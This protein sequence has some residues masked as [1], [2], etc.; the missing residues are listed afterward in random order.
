MFRSRTLRL[1]PLAAAC[2]LLT[3][4]RPA[5]AA[6]AAPV[7][8]HL[9]SAEITPGGYLDMTGVWRSANTGNSLATAFGAIPFDNTAA[10]H[11][12]ELRMTAQQ[13]RLNLRIADDVNGTRLAAYAEIDWSGNSAAN[14]WVDSNSQTLRMRQFW[15]SVSRGP[16]EFLAGQAW[17]WITPNRRGLS[18]NPAELMTTRNLDGF[19]NVGLAWTRGA[20]FRAAWHASGGFA[21]GVSLENPQQYVGASEVTFPSAFNAQLGVQAD[22]ANNAGT[23]NEMPD[24]V[25][26]AVWDGTT[27]GGPLH[28]EAVGIT[29]RFHIAELATGA[30]TFSHQSA[31]GTGAGAAVIA[32]LGTRLRVVASGLEGDGLGRY[33][34]GL[35]PDFV[36]Q[37]NA[38]GTDVALSTVHGRS[39]IAG[40]ESDLTPTDMIAGYYGEMD[41]DRDAFLDTT[42]PVTPTPTIGFGGVNSPGSANRTIHELT[43]D[44]SHAFWKTP[45]HGALAL[46]VQVSELVRKPGFVAA[47]APDHALVDMV[48]VDVRYTL[49]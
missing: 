38:A 32:N 13:S 45:D 37:P 27:A 19:T 43:V 34:G 3:G 26:K 48:Y 11:L 9:G 36:V 30:T 8:F 2:L 44:A 31:M 46:V 6:D 15:A 41:F 10:G 23:P 24:V 12:T 39:Y 33:M 16:W 20:Q 40:L 5:H 29:R 28:L 18:S 21:L 42:S 25:A 17:S 14:L 35:G 47:G 22:A 1:L 49:P 4:S 7:S